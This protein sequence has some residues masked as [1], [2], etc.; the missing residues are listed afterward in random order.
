MTHEEL[1]LIK[2]IDS[3]ELKILNT[4][5]TEDYLRSPIF[6]KIISEIDLNFFK[7]NNR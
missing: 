6:L 4:P 1:N 2:L 7:K 3:I 5:N